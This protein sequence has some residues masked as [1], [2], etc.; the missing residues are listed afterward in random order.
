MH[1]DI[2]NVLPG[3]GPEAIVRMLA[4]FDGFEKETLVERR[5]AFGSVYQ[6]HASI[7]AFVDL[8][9][10]DNWVVGFDWPEWNEGRELAAAP[11][12]IASVDLLTIR[13]LMTALV[14]NDRFCEG[15]L[16]GAYERGV[17]RAILLRI[18][19]LQEAGR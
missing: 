8:V 18:A 15:T 4:L 17:I 19:T 3:P 16:Q 1:D 7:E 2:D 6:E 9:N 5:G 11:E 12:R 13:K 10:E 14:R